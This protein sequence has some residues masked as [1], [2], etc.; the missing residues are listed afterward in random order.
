MET[1]SM[2][3]LEAEKTMRAVLENLLW[4]FKFFSVVEGFAWYYGIRNTSMQEGAAIHVK[5]RALP[6]RMKIQGLVLTGFA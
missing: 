1:C 5:F 3:K 6:F 4:R 2:A